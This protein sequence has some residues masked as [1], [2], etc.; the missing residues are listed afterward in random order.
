MAAAEAAAAA[1]TAAKAASE[2]GGPPPT[3]SIFKGWV[4]DD[5]SFDH[6]AIEKLPDGELKGFAKDVL[7]RFKND[8]EMLESFRHSHS[9][10][11]RK[12]LMPLP[13]GASKE[14]REAYR[15]R[16]A[17]LQNVPKDPDGYKIAKPEGVPDEMWDKGHVS[18]M[19]KILHE[20]LVDPETVKKIVAAEVEYERGIIAQTRLAEQQAQAEAINGLKK[21]WGSNYDR[22]VVLAAR[23][24]RTLGL[25]P[26]NPV[27]GNSPEV[28][29]AM[30]KMSQLVSEHVLVD[31]DS[32][33]DSPVGLQAQMQD[34]MEKNGAALMDPMNPKNAQLVAQ[35]TELAKK[36]AASQRRSG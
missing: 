36:I 7:S 9:L 19:A 3:G 24:A 17:E 13:A 5:G 21:E 34:F 28:M 35:Q 33:S 1:A 12:G 27:I 32:T 8:R 30:V 4:K 6:S 2:G 14:D 11:G 29:R 15:A 20:G 16:L 23:A 18:T 10:N 25:D 22:N 26:K 31:A